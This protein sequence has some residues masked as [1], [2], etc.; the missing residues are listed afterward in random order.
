MTVA[1]YM[2]VLLVAIGAASGQVS[3]AASLDSSIKLTD[4]DTIL[5]AN[6]TNG[7]GDESF[8]DALEQPLRVSLEE[9]PFLSVLSGFTVAATLRDMAHPANAPLTPEISRALCQ[10]THCKAYITGS[11]SREGTE[12]LI[13]LQA[14]DC[15]SGET[16]AQAQSTA[17]S[18][19]KVLDALGE[20]VSKLRVELG[21]PPESVREFST[22]LS[23]ATSLSFEALRA[24]GAA[25]RAQQE[26]VDLVEGS[27]AAMPL[28]ENAIKLDPDF[29]N[30]IFAIGLIFRD[31]LQEAR[32]R[33]YLI[34]AFACASAPAYVKS[35]AMRACTTASSR[36]NTRRP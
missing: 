10:R 3:L 1:R 22:P 12:F 34:R 32:A 16:L 8:N 23:R 15:V 13:G 4:K 31:A 28:L 36:S 18:K 17:Q 20:A 2:F 27:Q 6:F 5:L 30:A 11:I 29:A 21:E 9:S 26:N 24:W 7:T 14:V 33:E 35:F 19:E 25:M